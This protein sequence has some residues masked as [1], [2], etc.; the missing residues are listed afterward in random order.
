LADTVDYGQLAQRL[1]AVVGGAPVRLLET[2]AQ[3]LADECLADERVAAVTVRAHKPDAPI[4]LRFADVAVAIR[5]ARVDG[6]IGE[7]RGQR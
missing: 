2:L 4:P 5:R 3:R 1:A 6:P 7:E